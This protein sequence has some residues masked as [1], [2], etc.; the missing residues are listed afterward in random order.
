VSANNLYN[1]GY[2]ALMDFTEAPVEN[3]VYKTACVASAGIGGASAAY[4]P[5]W[6]QLRGLGGGAN[7]PLTQGDVEPSDNATVL[8]RAC[9]QTGFIEFLGNP[10]GVLGYNDIS[11]WCPWP[12]AS[13]RRYW[14]YHY[15]PWAW[16]GT[17]PQVIADIA[18]K[19]GIA[20]S[21]ID[22][23]AFDNAH[24]AY[25]LT[26]GDAPY[27]TAGGLVGSYSALGLTSKYEIGCN[28]TV[29]ESCA[30]LVA[31]CAR[32]SRDMYF[33]NEA[34][35]FSVQSYTRPAGS[36]TS[37]SIADGIV[38]GI[39]WGYENKNMFNKAYLS[40]GSGALVSGDSVTNP[41]TG[42]FSATEEAEL[43]SYQGEQMSC[44]SESSLSISKYGEVQMRGSRSDVNIR[45]ALV[46]A[47]KVHYPFH[48]SPHSGLGLDLPH[49]SAWM[50]STGK[51]PRTV[52]IT[53]DF[54]ALDWGIGSKVLNVAVTDDGQTIPE[55]WC[56][57]RTY[58][59]DRLTV[60]S[61]LMEQPPNT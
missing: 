29:G 12:T 2:F 1:T 49:I 4:I 61:V 40:W 24:D 28:R 11:A 30:D 35:A 18:M 57:E 20:S 27:T 36:V 3:S 55:M 14:L 51:I 33:V 41:N 9:Y 39:E 13:T 7:P 21:Q 19:C 45:G 23:A 10:R 22:M 42:G 58:D 43:E 6:K 16:F 47:S 5:Q 48:F 44:S 59:F 15:S 32:H 50:R 60:T 37:L 31:K 17:V 46:N 52:T 38:G 8:Y 34:G 56:I 25:D 26:T 54:R 53:Q